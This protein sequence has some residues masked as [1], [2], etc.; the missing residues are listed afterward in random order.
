MHLKRQSSSRDEN[1]K[2][3][4]TDMKE[5]KAG[6]SSIR[7]LLEDKTNFRRQ[8]TALRSYSNAVSGEV[9]IIQ[10]KGVQTNQKT[11]SVI[12]KEIDPN[13]IEVGIAGVKNLKNGAV[14]IACNNAEDMKKFKEVANTTLGADYDIKVPE[15]RIPMIKIV[16]LEREYDEEELK[17]SIVRQNDGI[18]DKI[19]LFKLVVVKKMLNKYMALVKINSELFKD[20]ME[21]RGSRVNVGWSRCQVYEYFD[22]IRCY[23]CGK[24]SHKAKDCRDKKVCLR[25]GEEGHEIKSCGGNAKCLNCVASNGKYKLNLDVNHS[26]FCHECPSLKRVHDV[27]SKRTNYSL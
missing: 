11:K 20:L 5:V 1:A 26:V 12:Q 17:I 9:V 6:L 21:R 4:D 7:D 8:Q 19:Q 13:S 25:C 27:I 2:I 24:Y 22:V 14:A 23:K 15:K 3:L 18:A 16:G 10:P